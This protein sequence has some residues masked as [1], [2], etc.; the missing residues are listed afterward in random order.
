[1]EC[2]IYCAMMSPS[3]ATA[4]MAASTLARKTARAT[5]NNVVPTTI[6]SFLDEVSKCYSTSAVYEL[7]NK[8]CNR[9]GNKRDDIGDFFLDPYAFEVYDWSDEL[10]QYVFQVV[11]EKVT[12]SHHHARYYLLRLVRD[13]RWHQRGTLLNMG[14]ATT[15]HGDMCYDFK[16]VTG[17]TTA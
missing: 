7:F 16:F 15:D 13:L 11:L 8:T 14:I 17:V 1:M 12:P 2:V 10:H 5:P 9:L 6:A 3:N 4:N